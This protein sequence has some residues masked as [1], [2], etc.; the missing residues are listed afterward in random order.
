ME[1]SGTWELETHVEYG[2]NPA[3]IAPT[4]P[5]HP[6]AHLLQEH[7]SAFG[8][9]LG[10]DTVY[11]RLSESSDTLTGCA[12]CFLCQYL[13]AAVWIIAQIQARDTV[14]LIVQCVRSHW[15]L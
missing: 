8:V 5:E 1:E 11:L 2:T 7:T 10:K 12:L 14:M 3:F 4:T 9:L 15:V 13:C 6:K